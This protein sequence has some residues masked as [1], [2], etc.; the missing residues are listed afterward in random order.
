MAGRQHA[1]LLLLLLLAACA[2]QESGPRYTSVEPERWPVR[3]GVPSFGE[4][5]SPPPLPAAHSCSPACIPYAQASNAACRWP[6]PQ[7][8]MLRVVLPGMQTHT[9]FGTTAPAAGRG[10]ASRPATTLAGLRSGAPF[11]MAATGASEAPCAAPLLS[12]LNSSRCCSPAAGPRCCWCTG[13]RC[14]RRHVL[15]CAALH[16]GAC[17]CLCHTPGFLSAAAL[18]AGRG[19]AAANAHGLTG[20]WRLPWL[21]PWPAGLASCCPCWSGC[22]SAPTWTVSWCSRTPCQICCK[23]WW[24]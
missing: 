22:V 11:P 16:Q 6:A 8:S 23:P 14:R 21:R 3:V 5:P 20:S 7:T 13:R 18:P 9:R 19:H 2:A 4:P 10:R 12:S 17:C 15:P 24:M 1:A